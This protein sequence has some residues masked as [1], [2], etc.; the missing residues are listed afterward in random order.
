MP[1]HDQRSLHYAC[2][3]TYTKYTRTALNTNLHVP[4]TEIMS[5]VSIFYCKLELSHFTRSAQQ[6]GNATINK[7][8]HW[9]LYLGT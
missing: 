3:R 4:N 8:L 7:C 5:T 2:K 9:N 6:L 1:N